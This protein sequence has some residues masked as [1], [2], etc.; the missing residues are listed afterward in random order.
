MPRQPRVVIEGHP[1]HVIQRGHNRDACF[2]DDHDR[3]FYLLELHRRADECALGVHAYVLMTNHVHLLVTPGRSESL[4]EGVG[5]LAQIYAQYFNAKYHRLGSP[6]HG[7]FGSK[8]IRTESHLLACHRYIELNPV[9]AGMVNHP[10]EWPW[11]SYAANAMGRVEPLLTPHPVLE[12]LAPTP[13]LRRTA[14]CDLFDEEL[15]EETLEAL[16]PRTRRGRPR[17]D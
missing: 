2:L 9:R 11:S 8:L 12:E 14:Y 16:R 10:A 3:R 15:S 4:S 1:F 7:R 13:E 6:W 5:W 17:E